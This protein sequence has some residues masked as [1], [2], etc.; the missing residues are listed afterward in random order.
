MKVESSFC[1]GKVI[2]KNFLVR[3]ECDNFYGVY[4]KWWDNSILGEMITSGKSMKIA[5]KKAKLLQIGYD[6]RKNQKNRK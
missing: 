2:F 3:K 4:E 6:I 5:S 1:D